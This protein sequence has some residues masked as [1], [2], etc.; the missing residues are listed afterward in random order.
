MRRRIGV[1]C[2][3]VVAML[4]SCKRAGNGAARIDTRRALT[5]LTTR[6]NHGLGRPAGGA[7]FDVFL[8]KLGT[9]AQLAGVGNGLFEALS[10]E[11][12]CAAGATR[13][14]DPIAESKQLAAIVEQLGA[15]NTN[16]L[17]SA[18]GAK[19]EAT[20]N[21][22][23]I[24]AGAA[25]ALKGLFAQLSLSLPELDASTKFD[26]FLVREFTEASRVA[27]W[28]KKLSTLNGGASPDAERATQ[29]FLD[30]MGSDERIDQ[31]VAKLVGADAAP[32]VV[33]SFLVQVLSDP[34]VQKQLV[35]GACELLD[36]PTV[37]ADTLQL[38]LDL[39]ELNPN[40]AEIVA[41]Q[42]KLIAGPV[43]VRVVQKLL[44]TVVASPQA[45]TAGAAALDR[46]VA[47]PQLRAAFAWFLDDWK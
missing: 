1:L 10:Q 30:N 25:A 21:S 43:A 5:E 12:R 31:F 20:W 40:V 26:D 19:A 23:P 38:I 46:L 28:S 44:D 13:I 33:A 14:L 11:P 35:N 2:L 47:D 32:S 8:G 41:L 34:S 3:V 22:P 37:Q 4:G 15:T 7:A 45:A 42:K 39:L 6:V 17:P 36:D 9:H 24:A 27:A 18:V 29:L 16:D